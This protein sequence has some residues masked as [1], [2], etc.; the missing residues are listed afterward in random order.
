MIHEGTEA[1]TTVALPRSL[2]I[3]PVGR[4]MIARGLSDV[5]MR[6]DGARGGPPGFLS[7][8]AFV[9]LIDELRGL[10]ELRLHGDGEP[11]AH[12]RFFDMVRHAADR[13]IA[14]SSTSRLQVFNHRLAEECVRSGLRA[15]HV[16]LDAAGTREYDFSRRGARHERLLRHLRWLAAAKKAQA[17]GTPRVTLGAVMMR[18][19]LDGLAQ[20]VRLAHENGA[21]G[22]VAQDL[23]SFVDAS[24]VSPAHQRI[25]K[26]VASEALGPGDVASVQARFAEAGALA[27][28]LGVDLRV[29]ALPGTEARRASCAWPWHA[30]YITFFGVA[31]SCNLAARDPGQE[32][33]NVLKDGFARVWQGEAYRRF[34]ERHLSGE[35]PA[36]C[37]QC[38]QAGGVPIVAQEQQRPPAGSSAP[39]SRIT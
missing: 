22:V 10:E 33:G 26:F 9:R 12:P 14:V 2:Q 30:S 15:L 16:Q 13:G 8:D 39:A 31:R 5:T 20:A 23:E 28:E 11:L 27:R 34:R 17:S 24:G 38:P 7:Y 3:E 1:T 4:R 18:R 35:L 21:D 36:L 37:A 19:N 25:R 29:P 6:V 32:F